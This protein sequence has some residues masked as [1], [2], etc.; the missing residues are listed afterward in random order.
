M[1]GT[2]GEEKEESKETVGFV[3]EDSKGGQR[4]FW[5]TTFPGKSSVLYLYEADR[6]RKR[7]LRTHHEAWEPHAPRTEVKRD[8]FP[9]FHAKV[10]SSREPD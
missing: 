4:P 10:G 7:V 6:I 3:A 5:H 9:Y 2:A 8:P 1:G